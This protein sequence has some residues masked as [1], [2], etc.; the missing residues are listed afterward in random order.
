M[1]V[2]LL[3]IYKEVIY[4]YIYT[5]HPSKLNYFQPIATQFY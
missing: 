2:A 4:I 3:G 5:E 1:H